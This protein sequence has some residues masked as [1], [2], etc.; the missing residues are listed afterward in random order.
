MS[1]NGTKAKAEVNELSVDLEI[2]NV[3]SAPEDVWESML[4]FSG[5]TDRELVAMR[6]TVDVLFQ[7]G[8]ELVVGTYEHLQRIPE[9]AE[10][11]GWQQGEDESHLSERRRFFTIWLAR[12][13][14]IDLGTDF[15]N[16]LFH[17]GQIHGA[18][19]PRKIHTPAMWVMGSMGL[20]LGAFAEFI[21]SAHSDVNVVAPALSGWNKYLMLQLNQMHAGYE[22]AVELDRGSHCIEVKAYAMV[23]VGWGQN[24]LDVHYSS[25]DRVVDVLRKVLDYSPRLRDVMFE[26]K[27]HSTDRDQ[28][29]WET[30]SLVYVLLAGWRVQLNGK[31]LQF[32]GG[33]QTELQPGDKLELV[34]PGR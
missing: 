25:G 27:W 23:R 29:L 5:P 14:S 1:T 7:R 2:P 15:A 31:N 19:G 12:T 13:I 17:A 9:T 28:D 34:S 30:I 22:T 26:K 24:K 20:I 18:H 33:F 21:Q 4:R 10:I 3:R 11:L 6:Q 8:Y 16:Y 32:H